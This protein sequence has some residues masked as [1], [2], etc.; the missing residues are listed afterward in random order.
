MTSILLDFHRLRA[1]ARLPARDA[2]PRAR[3]RA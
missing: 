3:A 2:R 1:A